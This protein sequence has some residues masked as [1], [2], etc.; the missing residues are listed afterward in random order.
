MF[1]FNFEYMFVVGFFLVFNL[2]SLLVLLVVNISLLLSI[3]STFV[4]FGFSLNIVTLNHFLILPAF[5]CEFFIYTT[6]SLRSD[7]PSDKS[8]ISSNSAEMKSLVKDLKLDS[9]STT[10]TASTKS[11]EEVLDVICQ[12]TTKQSKLERI[13]HYNL[14]CSFNYLICV[15]GLS[16]SLMYICSTY[17][18]ETLFIFLI[19]FSFNAYLHLV[20]FYPVLS[21]LLKTCQ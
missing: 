21:L 14:I 16:F 2:T 1:M 15:L 6:Y 13:F 12:L 11:A 8:L 10:T 20:L 9:E 17:N 7:P 3:L 5:M 4:L 18:F 19:S